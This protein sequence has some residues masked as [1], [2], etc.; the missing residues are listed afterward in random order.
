M[1]HGP[2]PGQGRKVSGLIS[3]TGFA[4][5]TDLGTQLDGKVRGSL[6]TFE[7]LPGATAKVSVEVLPSS[8]L[9]ANAVYALQVKRLE[10]SG[11][12]VSTNNFLAWSDA[13]PPDSGWQKHGTTEPYFT[14]NL[15][16]G[17]TGVYSFLLGL[18]ANTPVDVYDLEFAIAGVDEGGM[19]YA[20]EHY[21]LAVI[22]P[23]L[24]TDGAVTW[25][26]ALR[27]AGYKLEVADSVDGPW[28]EY[29]GP[30]AELEGNLVVLMKTATGTKRFF[31]LR[32]P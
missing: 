9:G 14:K 21:Y 28:Q 13:N 18:G 3:V 10:K 2:A 30:V 11:Q 1:C 12:K 31:R 22:S 32:A 27:E 16:Q 25:S 7:V 6:K 15:P 20:D 5:E 29:T 26:A 4:K 19:F 17:A 24:F 23:S 8:N